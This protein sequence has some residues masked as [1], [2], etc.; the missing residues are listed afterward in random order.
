MLFERPKLL[1]SQSREFGPHEHEAFYVP[2][3]AKT[4]ALEKIPV[5]L[6]KEY[7]SVYEVP[8]DAK[9]L[10]FQARALEADGDKVPIDLGL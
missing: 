5:G 3:G 7:W 8:K 9:G 10:K 1:D 2:E 4:L 6:K